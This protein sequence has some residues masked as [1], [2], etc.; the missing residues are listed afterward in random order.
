L[1]TKVHHRCDLHHQ[2]ARPHGFDGEP[3]EIA[4]ET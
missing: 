3:R 1:R 2:A 4:G